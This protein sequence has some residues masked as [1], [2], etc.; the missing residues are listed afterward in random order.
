MLQRLG[1][2]GYVPDHAYTVLD[3]RV[4]EHGASWVKLRHP[5]GNTE[6]DGDGVDDGIFEIPILEFARKFAWMAIGRE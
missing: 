2:R 6:P 4:D 1:D 5:W 3:I